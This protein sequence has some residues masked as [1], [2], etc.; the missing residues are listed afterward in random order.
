[1]RRRAVELFL[2]FCF[3]AVLSVLF[4]L[5][6]PYADDPRYGYVTAIDGTLARPFAYRALVPDVTA[7]T[8]AVMPGA[9][10]GTFDRGEVAFREKA[11]IRP[12]YGFLSILRCP[13]GR[14][15]DLQVLFCVHF[16]LF[17][18]FSVLMQ[19]LGTIVLAMNRP[20]ALAFGLAVP[21]LVPT[22][23]RGYNQI[24]DPATLAVSA[25]L[26]LAAARSNVPAFLLAFLLAA[27]N[28]ESAIVF[29]PLVL[30]MPDPR[31]SRFARW[32]TLAAAIVAFGLIRYVLLRR[33]E[34]NAGDVFEYTWW[35]NLQTFTS[36]PGAMASILTF[37]GSWIALAVVGWQKK[38]LFLRRAL[39]IVGI[40]FALAILIYGQIT[41]LRV[42]FELLPIL[43]CLA[44]PTVMGW[45]RE[46]PA[47]AP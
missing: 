17:F 6:S 34:G 32:G 14:L 30:A 10:R 5:N 24:Y 47:T 40:P 2:R 21:L 33:F 22:F 37:F 38:D 35:V 44:A 4:T 41:E 27:Y 29:A 20:T 23:F 12:V 26:L 1:M 11:D 13:P 25:G 45:L 9:L 42:W 18:A 46:E 36:K 43:A 19:R 31:V 3:T 7:T 8:V 15:A 16:G 28:K 39:L